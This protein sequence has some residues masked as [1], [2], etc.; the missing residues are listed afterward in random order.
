MLGVF[1]SIKYLCDFLRWEKGITK[2]H[3]VKGREEGKQ[4]EVRKEREEEGREDGKE[5]GRE[6]GNGPIVE[7]IE[8][9]NV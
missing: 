1:F 3:Y 7:Y 4:A 9:H 8:A 2:L 5:D 6:E